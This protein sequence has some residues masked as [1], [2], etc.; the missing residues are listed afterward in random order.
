MCSSTGCGAILGAYRRSG[1]RNLRQLAQ[2]AERVA[3]VP[4][5]PEPVRP[6]GTVLRDHEH[7][8]E[9]AVEERPELGGRFDRG[10]EVPGVERRRDLWIDPLES[11]NQL[12]LR[13]LDEERRIERV[14]SALLL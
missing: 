1:A 11:L 12:G 8:L 13:L 14:G 2:A 9:E 7:V 6:H 3:H 5:Q 10:A 4:Q